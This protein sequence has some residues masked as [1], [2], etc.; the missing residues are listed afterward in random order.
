MNSFAKTLLL[1]FTHLLP[2][3]MTVPI[4]A[5]PLKWKKWIVGAAAGE[6]R[7][8]S[9][10]INQMESA[11]VDYAIKILNNNCICF[12]IGANVGFYTLL[13]SK[14]AKE[15]YAF[16]PLPRNLKYLIRL[17]EVNKITNAKIIPC[18][19]SDSSKIS[20]F[21][22]GDNPALG[23]LSDDGNVPV[24]V[25]TCD[26]FVSKTNVVPDL[27]KIDVEGSEL[28]VFRGANNLLKSY[29]PSILLSVHSDQLRTDCLNFLKKMG[30]RSIVPIDSEQLQEATEFAIHYDH[31]NKEGS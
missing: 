6:G 2:R 16:E 20:Y 14:Y 19:V 22:E 24:L 8:M 30:Y 5:G 11:Q 23:N 13:F 9:I 25:T 12:D 4:V 21:S 28:N 31:N 27:L 7:G 15:V 29:H 26:Q 1:P 17:S 18:A 3:G 10:I